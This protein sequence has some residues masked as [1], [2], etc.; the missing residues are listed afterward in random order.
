GDEIVS[1][2]D[3]YGGSY[4]LFTKIYQDFG[5]KFHFVGMQDPEEIEKHINANTKMIWVETPT[6]P[7]MNIIDIEATASIAKKHGVLL[8]VDNTFATAYLQRPLE[9]GADI[10]MHSA[11][12]YLGGHS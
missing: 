6:N 1:T 10:V 3:L 11:T 12:K 8:A 2:N 7:M 5:L 9:L 4:R